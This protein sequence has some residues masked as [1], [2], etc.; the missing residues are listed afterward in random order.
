MRKLMWFT[1][2][3]AIA[4][5]LGTY[6]LRHGWVMAV[7]AVCALALPGLLR[8]REHPWVKR[9]VA[10]GLGCAVGALAFFGYEWFVLKP[11]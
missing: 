2:G 11:L 7:A 3:Y 9:A 5:G 4:C 8:F 1:I 10:L 6:L